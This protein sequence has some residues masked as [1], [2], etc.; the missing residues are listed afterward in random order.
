MRIKKPQFTTV[1]KGH[2]N[3]NSYLYKCKI[4]DNPR[5]QCKNGDQTVQNVIFECTDLTKEGTNK[6]CGE[7][8]T[9]LASEF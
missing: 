3:I 1:T 4:I 9:K 5:C 6:N 2:S 8:D 7:E